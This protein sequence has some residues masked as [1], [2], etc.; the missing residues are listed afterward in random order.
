MAGS[1]E[2]PPEDA[3]TLRFSAWSPMA[4][5]A[6]RAGAL[7]EEMMPKGMLANE[8]GEFLGIENQ[9]AMTE[10]E[11]EGESYDERKQDREQPAGQINSIPLMTSAAEPSRPRLL[12]AVALRANSAIPAC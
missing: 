1:W 12:P 2:K 9:E 3:K 4:M 5:A 10:D 6:T 8:K 11:D 7:A